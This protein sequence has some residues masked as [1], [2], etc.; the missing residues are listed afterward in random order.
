[1][2][3]SVC[4]WRTRTCWPTS[5]TVGTRKTTKEREAS[6][7]SRCGYARSDITAMSGFPELVSRNA[8]VFTTTERS[9]ASSWYHLTCVCELH[10]GCGVGGDGGGGGGV[11]HGGEVLGRDWGTGGMW[12]GVREMESEV[13]AA[14]PALPPPSERKER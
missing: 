4:I 14:M 8:T 3:R 9:S 6:L 7:R 10:G 5:T 11:W 12:E 2:W 13:A 1:M